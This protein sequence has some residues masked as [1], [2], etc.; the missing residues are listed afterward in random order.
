MECSRLCTPWLA[1]CSGSLFLL[2]LLVMPGCGAFGRSV[3]GDTVAEFDRR[4]VA[5]LARCF[6]DCP[7]PVSAIRETIRRSPDSERR[8]EAYV[9]GDYVHVICVGDDGGSASVGS[10]ECRFESNSFVVGR[11]IFGDSVDSRCPD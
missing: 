7:S 6:Q 10:R 11:P 5:R 3:S 9:C 4:E 8:Y 2:L 1:R